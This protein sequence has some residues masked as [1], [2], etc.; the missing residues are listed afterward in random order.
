MTVPYSI[1]V[2]LTRCRILVVGA[3]RVA[4]RKIR[5]L[6]EAGGRPDIVAPRF[7]PPLAQLAI[8][9]GLRCSR[10]AFAAGDTRGHHLVFVATDDRA[11]NA[12]I[13]RE[14]AANGALVNVA[15]STAESTFLVP[16]TLRQGEVTVALS[17]AGAAPV[18]ARRLRD[19]LGETV[20]PGV[21][22]A[23]ARLRQLREEVRARWSDEPARRRDF[24]L[25]LV[26]PELLDSAVAGRDEEVE[27]AISR[28]LSQ[29]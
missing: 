14:A 2:D 8:D 7:H 27:L 1:G 25:R 21:G 20:T 13:A 6:L 4:E 10:R 17:T 24:W 22:R 9:R 23:A 5:G 28:C 15:D 3:G 11:V 12:C 26:S 29:S 18:F 19:R 16:A